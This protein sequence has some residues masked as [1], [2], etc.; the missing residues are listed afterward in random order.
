MFDDFFKDKRILVTG[1]TGV[2]GS[3]L[4][5]ELL[6]AGS[7]VVG[8][9]IRS[10]QLESNFWAAGLRDKITYVQGDVTDLPLMRRLLTGVDGVFHL[11]AVALVQQAER[12]PLEAYRTNSM[13]TATVL[14]ALRLSESVQ[15]AVFVTSD[16]G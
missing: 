2:K 12:E 5:L 7:R 13:G 11:A 3:W 10:P 8:L 4:A 14:E 16:K 1:V 9:D 6:E 15:H